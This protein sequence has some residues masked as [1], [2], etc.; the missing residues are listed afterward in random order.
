MTTLRHALFVRVTHWV[1]AI[2]VFALLVSGAEIVLSH[3]RFYWGEIG[4][5][6][7][8]PI[9]TLPVPASRAT[10]P[11]GYDFVL[12]DQN[13]WS[14]FLHFQTAWLILAAGIAYVILGIRSGHFR[15]HLVPAPRD[16]SWRALRLQIGDHLRFRPA[17]VAD[18]DSY[19]VVQRLS[20]IAVV[21][22]LLPLLFWTGLAMSPA[23]TG[24]MP[25]AVDLLGGRQ[26][27]RTLHFFATIALATFTVTHLAML[28][29]AGFGPR[30]RAMITGST[31]TLR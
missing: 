19:N 30:V 24:M 16:R 8:D 31:E 3:P 21:F 28:V 29:L 10:V 1:A 12:A 6:N 5:V 13:G 23:V 18:P 20:Y 4:N 7:V 26:S 11:T 15:H 25:A 2:G 22:G 17:A 9:F 14:R 27:A